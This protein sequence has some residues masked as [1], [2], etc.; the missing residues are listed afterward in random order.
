MND[1]IAVLQ[2]LNERVES[3]DRELVAQR[4]QMAAQSAQLTTVQLQLQAQREMMAVSSLRIILAVVLVSLPNLAS[5]KQYA[6]S[7]RRPRFTCSIAHYDATAGI[8]G[9]TFSAHSGKFS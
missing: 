3:Q 1:V 7:F 9:Y 2:R 8:D 6:G 4:E 5:Q